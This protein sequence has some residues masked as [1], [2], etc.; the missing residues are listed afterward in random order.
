MVRKKQRF[1]I[2]KEPRL[3][4]HPAVQ[5]FSLATPAALLL[6]SIITG[7]AHISASQFISAPPKCSI[8]VNHIE[9]KVTLQAYSYELNIAPHI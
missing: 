8:S 7:A 3:L 2:D 5:P 6:Y 4:V 9:L 1:R